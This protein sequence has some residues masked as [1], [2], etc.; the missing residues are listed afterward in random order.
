MMVWSPV[1]GR[2]A[3]F[4]ESRYLITLLYNLP[5]NIYAKFDYF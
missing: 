5:Y 3:H 2:I 4:C 1:D